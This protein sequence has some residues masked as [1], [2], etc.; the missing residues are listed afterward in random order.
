MFTD[1]PECSRQFR[2]RADQIAAAAGEV[3]CGFCG[4][5]FNVLERLRDS[6][7]PA[8]PEAGLPE[9]QFEIAAPRSGPPPVRQ[10]PARAPE[11]PPQLAA[12][13]APE[14]R[15]GRALWSAVAL[16]FVL[17]AAA[18]LAWF[19]RDALIGSYPVL[20]PWAER[21]C[22]RLGCRVIEFRDLSAI[23]LV[24]RDVRLHPLYQRALLDNATIR[25][26][27][28]HAQ[29]WPRLQLVLFDTEGR[30]LAERAFEPREY[31]DASIDVRTGMRPGS[32]AH[33]VLEIAG[34]TESAVSFEFGF[35]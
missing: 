28:A 16:L 8:K 14:P 11:V 3:R 33:L 4:R 7:L 31:L 27:A 30:A 32:S 25:N 12:E 24:N 13:S 10:R 26:A 34:A 20:R 6:P 9:P 18:Q 17:L 1:C 21:L 22:A 15:P 2:V 29:P 23:E 19:N 35:M 5:Q